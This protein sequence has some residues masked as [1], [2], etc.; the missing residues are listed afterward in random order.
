MLSWWMNKDDR[1]ERPETTTTTNGDVRKI[2][3][4]IQYRNGVS[5]SIKKKESRQTE[6]FKFASEW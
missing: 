4:E 1:R 2:E 5:C 3:Q 6:I